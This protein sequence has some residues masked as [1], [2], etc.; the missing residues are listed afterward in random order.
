MMC[1]H[2]LL[3]GLVARFFHDDITC[4]YISMLI[5]SLCETLILLTIFV[6]CQGTEY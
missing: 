4:G 1:T 3:L 5:T 2:W 6:A